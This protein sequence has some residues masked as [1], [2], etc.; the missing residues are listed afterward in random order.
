MFKVPRDSYS[1]LSPTNVNTSLSFRC[2]T[3]PFQNRRAATVLFLG[4]YCP[5]RDSPVPRLI[6]AREIS[7]I[8][9]FGV[10]RVC[11]KMLLPCTGPSACRAHTSPC[12]SPVPRLIIARVL[13]HIHF[14]RGKG[15]C[16]GA[17]TLHR[18]FLLPC[19]HKPVPQSCSSADIS[20][21]SRAY[22]FLAWQGCVQRCCY[23]V[24][25]LR[26]AALTQG[27]NGTCPFHVRGVPGFRYAEPLL[28][29]VLA[30]YEAFSC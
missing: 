15:V 11:A 26:P 16:K 5:S 19:S 13:V 25:T 20:K 30:S 4:L 12:H 22:S 14:W 9:T 29:Y 3:C 2:A 8:L 27:T 28:V 21:G 1:K 24:S 10:A 7:C 6:L 23:L 18:P 17:V